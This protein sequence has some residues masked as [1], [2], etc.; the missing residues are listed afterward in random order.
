MLLTGAPQWPA[1]G[2]RPPIVMKESFSSYI[3]DAAACK[4]S[5]LSHLA[6]QKLVIGQDARRNEKVSVPGNHNLTHHHRDSF[7][8]IVNAVDFNDKVNVQAYE[9]STLFVAFEI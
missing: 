2:M 7:Q 3:K 5:D 1:V 8:R 6:G 9:F 4:Q